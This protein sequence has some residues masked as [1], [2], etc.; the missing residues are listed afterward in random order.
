MAALCLLAA[1][2]A[3]RGLG[4][5]FPFRSAVLTRHGESTRVLAADGS[6]LRI[7]PTPLGE[8][9]IRVR[10]GD[11]PD[12]LVDAL[13]TSEDARFCTHSGVD[14][15]AVLRAGVT[16]L[17]RRRVVSG[18]STLTMQLARILEPHRRSFANKILEMFRA[19][20]IE[21]VLSKDEIL[22]TYASLVPL[23]GLVRGFAAA[24]LRWFGK[25]VRDLSVAEAATLVAMLPAPSRR[26]PRRNP[27]LLLF[28][29]DRLLRS[30]SARGVLSEAACA[31]ALR[32]PLGAR[33]RAW[34]FR[35]AHAC[36]VA[37]SRARGPLIQT[38]LD[39]GLQGRVDRCVRER[40]AG[41]ADGVAVVVL[42]RA[43]GVIRALT[44][45]DDW[46]RVQLDAAVCSR[47]AGSTLKPFLYALALELGVTSLD[48]VVSDSPVV[49]ARWSP[50]NFDGR[51]RGSLLA[52]DALAASRNMPAIELL[53]Q[54]GV[55]RFRDVLEQLGIA[56]PSASLH[57]DAAL[58][59]LGV[60]PLALAAAYRRFAASEAD[61]AGIRLAHRRAVLAVLR[62]SSPNPSSV[63]VGTVAWKTGTSSG[64]R[65]AWSVGVTA[66][67]VIVV[68]TGN[69]SGRGAADLVG[70]R[71]ANELLASVLRATQ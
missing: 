44:G 69:L 35:A 4:M 34:P 8:R 27:Q 40:D 3:E 36:E 5:L 64:R 57:L 42:D 45:S 10:R 14:L 41:R 50:R 17:L 12:A 24:S 7:S 60:T 19:R 59:T 49:F 16:S 66:R 67:Y 37:M 46:H 39:V 43:S 56:T 23:G 70:A 29:R 21:R 2:V 61:V 20:Q 22:E 71:L 51:Y 1:L 68:W 52:A 15:L 11:L 38:G 54:V 9:L 48:A 55:E 30:M 28:H 18:A 47:P 25:N 65:D 26:S 62:R 32:E 33:R 13:L 6:L 53:Q 63:A 58:G 31:R